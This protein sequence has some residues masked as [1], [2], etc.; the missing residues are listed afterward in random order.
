[1]FSLSNNGSSKLGT[2]SQPLVQWSEVEGH[3]GLMYCMTQSSNNPIVLMVR[4]DTIQVQ[5]IKAT[6]AKAKVSVGDYVNKVLNR[7]ELKYS[8]NI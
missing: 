2:S 3:T 1:M 8:Y 6:S 4:P 7:I 5:E